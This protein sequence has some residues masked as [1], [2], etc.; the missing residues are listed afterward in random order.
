MNQLARQP[1]YLHAQ[2]H[3]T[4]NNRHA[5]IFYGHYYKCH[6]FG[7]KFVDCRRIKVERD[8]NYRYNKYRNFRSQNSPLKDRNVFSPLLSEV[9]CL[10]CNNFGHKASECRS[11]FENL[12][13]FQ[14]IK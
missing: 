6:I 8:E 1:R 13:K 11:R 5:Y 7:H 2:A 14:N 3:K 9:E 4:S 12:S 10:K